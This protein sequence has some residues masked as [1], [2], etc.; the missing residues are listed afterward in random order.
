MDQ[1]YDY[2]NK[3]RVESFGKMVLVGVESYQ[4]HHGAKHNMEE[5]LI[6]DFCMFFCSP[7]TTTS[8]VVK[9][10][11]GGRWNTSREDKKEEE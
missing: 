7:S 6:N 11:V 2:Y 8:T 5:L 3:G 10:H 9:K 1:Y 4:S